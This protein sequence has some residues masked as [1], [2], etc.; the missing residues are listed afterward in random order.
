MAGL[1][2]STIK[3]KYIQLHPGQVLMKDSRQAG[4]FH[5]WSVVG[6]YP[7]LWIAALVPLQFQFDFEQKAKHLAVGFMLFL[8]SFQ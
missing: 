1:I 2:I 3:G 7:H 5:L 6:Q 4:L 8:G